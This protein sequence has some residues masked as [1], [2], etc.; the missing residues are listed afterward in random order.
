MLA[1]EAEADGDI[2]AVHRLLA[3]MTL[4]CC[5]VDGGG[6]EDGDIHR[7][8]R[9]RPTGQE[10]RQLSHAEEWLSDPKEN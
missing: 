2:Q 10:G 7:D 4:R 5:D 1:V 3:I 9:S 8:D 6:K